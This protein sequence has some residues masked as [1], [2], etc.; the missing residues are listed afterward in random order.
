M[1]PSDEGSQSRRKLLAA[2]VEETTSQLRLVRKVCHVVQ[3]TTRRREL[4]RTGQRRTKTLVTIRLLAKYRV[5][6]T[7]TMSVAKLLLPRSAWEDCD[8]QAGTSCAEHLRK[9]LAQGKVVTLAEKVWEQRA[10]PNSSRTLMRVKRLVAEY[11]VYRKL[12]IMNQKGVTPKKIELVTWLTQYWPRSGDATDALLGRLAAR[13][14]SVTKWMRRFRRF[15]HISF[16]KL[17]IR[18]EVTPEMQ[19]VKVRILGRFWLQKVV[20][21]LEQKV[22]SKLEPFLVI[23]TGTS[24]TKTLQEVT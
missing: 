1:P 3:H 5:D 20:S 18:G 22:V 11:Q 9:L 8:S 12:L 13:E 6:E 4:Q 10:M 15:W 2:L 19:G 16:G 23:K 24:L 14:K 7:M 21:K 17:P